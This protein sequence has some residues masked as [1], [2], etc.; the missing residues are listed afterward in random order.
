MVWS[1]FCH[2]C[3]KCDDLVERLKANCVQTGNYC[4]KKKMTLQEFG[5]FFVTFSD[6][7]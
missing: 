7:P 5:S 2:L 4:T 3:K 6:T 1:G